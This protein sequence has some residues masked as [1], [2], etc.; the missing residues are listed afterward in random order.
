MGYELIP[1]TTSPMIGKR[2]ERQFQQH[3]LAPM[4]HRAR[5]T[6]I[7]F[8]FVAAATDRAGQ[9][10]TAIHEAT[11]STGDANLDMD[12]AYIRQTGVRGIGSVLRDSILGL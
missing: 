12:L 9:A 2:A 6:D 8:Q 3:T 4:V 1:A 10:V 7:K 11:R 5:T